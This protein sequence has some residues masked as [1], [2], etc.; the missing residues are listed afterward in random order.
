MLITLRNR[1]FQPISL[2]DLYQVKSTLKP[3]HSFLTTIKKLT[4]NNFK[5]TAFYSFWLIAKESP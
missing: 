1:T 2:I 4:K 5:Q 3:Y